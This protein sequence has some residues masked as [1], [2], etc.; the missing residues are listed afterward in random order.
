MT[1]P[2]S[3]CN[4]DGCDNPATQVG[5]APLPGEDVTLRLCDEHVAKLRAGQVR[6]VQ[7]QRGADG[8]M[9]QAEVFFNE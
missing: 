8:R 3:T 4:A 2:G 1:T 6:S 9:R 5:Q 7:R